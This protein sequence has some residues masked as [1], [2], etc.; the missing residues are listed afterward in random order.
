MIK[1]AI[2]NNNFTLSLVSS[3][4]LGCPIFW[5]LVAIELLAICFSLAFLPTVI[6]AFNKTSLFH[7]NLV[8][9]TQLEKLLHGVLLVT[10][11]FVRLWCLNL[12]IL[13]LPAVIIE[14]IFASK[15]INDYEKY[16]RPWIHRIIIPLAVIIS[17]ISAFNDVLGRI[18]PVI[19]TT[20]AALFF[21][22]YC[23]AYV[24]LF[25]RDLR[26]MRALDKGL[27]HE[28][29]AYTLS[30]KFQLKENLR[31]MKVLTQLSLMWTTSSVISCCSFA[32]AKTVLAHLLY[33]NQMS[34]QIVDVSV[35]IS[36]VIITS[37]FAVNLGV[38]ANIGSFFRK[39]PSIGTGIESRALSDHRGASDAYFIQLTRSWKVAAKPERPA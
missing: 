38:A 7:K 22:A 21:V 8:R 17:A 1:V 36:F 9:I 3:K 10:A 4:P 6:R 27:Y 23:V 25:R 12:M 5:T 30:T 35:A 16:P 15:Y 28:D 26:R 39:K 20:A 14:R 29:T 24:I 18:N 2:G 19:I 31:M 11:C 37:V 34:H 33:W 32:L 13:Y